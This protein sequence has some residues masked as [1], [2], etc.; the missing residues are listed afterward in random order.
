MSNQ[1][2][3]ITGAAGAIGLQ[4]LK[5]LLADNF[6]NM[7][8]VAS[9][10]RP[11][12]TFLRHEKLQ[13]LK[14]DIRAPEASELI[15]TGNFHGIIHLASIVSPGKHSN[16]EFEYSVDVIGTKNVLEACRAGGVK[17]FIVT[18]SG[19]AYGYHKDL[20]E[21][22]SEDEPVRGNQVFAYSWHKKLVEDMLSDYRSTHPELKQLILRP[23]TVLGDMMKNQITDLFEKPVVLGVSGSDSPFVFIWD[24]D[25]AEIIYQGMLQG[26]TGIY[27]LAGDGKVTN[28]EL[29]K[30]LKKPLVKIPT[31]VLKTALAILKKF[32]LTQYGPD[33]IDFLKYR[34]VLDNKRLKTVFGFT[35]RFS[36]VEVLKRY[37]NPQRRFY[38]RRAGDVSPIRPIDVF[39]K[40]N[41]LDDLFFEL[42]ISDDTNKK[43]AFEWLSF[44]ESQRAGTLYLVEQ[45]SKSIPTNLLNHAQVRLVT[46][47]Q[48]KDLLQNLKVDKGYHSLQDQ[49]YSNHEIPST[50]PT[51]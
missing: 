41:R 50:I 2:W 7:E 34:P 5:R 32:Q 13:F 43:E 45:D 20:P 23:G 42:S 30:I 11:L 44:F 39:L 51:V 12:P 14:L 36:S 33:Q 24:Q 19:A 28:V 35:P 25:V 40:M 6:K 22:I 47:S 26:K 38:V 48:A 21:W 46:S 29:A 8:V 4:V 31:T 3:L 15:K 9:D 18:S 37:L 17:H 1:R 27:N 49:L 16:R 10:V